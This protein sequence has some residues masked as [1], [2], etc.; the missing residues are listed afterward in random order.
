MDLYAFDWRAIDENNK[1]A[2][3]VCFAKKQNGDVVMV[4]IRQ[5]FPS[6][7][8]ESKHGEYDM[9]TTNDIT[10]IRRF[11]KHSFTSFR[12]M[13][14]SHAFPFAFMCHEEPICHFLSTYNFPYVGWIHVPSTDCDVR[15]ITLVDRTDIPPFRIVSFDIEVYSCTRTMPKSY[16]R[17]DK[18][19]MISVVDGTKTEVIQEDDEMVCIDKF[20]QVIER[21]DP[22]IITG[23][24]I[25]NFDFKYIRDRLELRLKSFPNMSRCSTIPA[26]MNELKW[27]NASYGN[28]DFVKPDIPG[29]IVIDVFQYFKR[30]NSLD[31]YSLNRISEQFLGEQ[32][33]DLSIDDMMK[34]YEDGYM[35]KIKEY[36]IKDSLLVIRLIDKF[37]IIVDLLEQS[38]ILKCKID[39]ILTRGEQFKI[40]HHL[41]FE[42]V[43]RNVILASCNIGSEGSYGGG[44]VH[45]PIPGVY[46][47][48]VILDY[49]SLY[50]SVIISNNICPS[51]YTT[52]TV[53]THAV[54]VG[55]TIHHFRKSPTGILSGLLETLLT[56]RSEIKKKMGDNIVLNKRQN[57]LKIAANSIYGITGAKY[58]KYLRHK[59]CA[60]S[61]T[62]GGRYYFN[63]L[64]D[65]VS[66]YHLI[67]GDTDSCILSFPSEEGIQ[68]GKDI[69]HK[70]NQ[71]LPYPVYLKYESYSK[72]MIIFSKKKYIMLDTN[73]SITY[74]GVTNAR[75][76][77]CTFVKKMYENIIGMV[78]DGISSEIILGYVVYRINHIADEPITEFV[79]TKSVKSVHDYVTDVPQKLMAE[80][81]ISEGEDIIA[82]I[83]LE[84]VFVKNNE[85]K[86]G[87]KMYRPE[88]IIPKNLEID[89]DYYIKKQVCST[90]DQVLELLGY[91]NFVKYFVPF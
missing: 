28:H 19:F 59:Y 36:C 47:H 84:Y 73:N 74:K 88:E 77:Y 38:R 56:E 48:C 65:Y 27:A 6:Y 24:N 72:K 2:T 78:F 53:N 64:I 32:K 14:Q 81:L 70:Y 58:S 12:E 91:P 89:Y 75:R 31:S 49:Q 86:Q 41:V 55:H 37:D 9:V 67:Y 87:L 90:I 3:I 39:D 79:I 15:Y 10:V 82:G 11:E 80:R 46:E 52:L 33:V 18:I 20:C 25:F 60:E 40:N 57:A 85:K 16:R 69:C 1:K 35:D 34:Q 76:G 17:K 21:L 54:D 4:K 62:G 8:V 26:T 30:M 45:E 66:S 44:L 5:Y 71:E 42:C 7:Y 13:R 43:R 83:R 61:I 68:I 22:D 23:F 29:R 51:T 50:P 63:K